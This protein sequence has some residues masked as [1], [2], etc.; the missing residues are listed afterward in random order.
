M[1]DREMIAATLAA[2]VLGSSKNISADEQGADMAIGFYRQVLAALAKA[3]AA[4]HPTAGRQRR[5]T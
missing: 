3:Q 4:E 2:G 5:L 1:A